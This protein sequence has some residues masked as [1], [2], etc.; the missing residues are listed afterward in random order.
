[1]FNTDDKGIKY[2][3]GIALAL[4][5]VVII[6][7]AMGGQSLFVVGVVIGVAAFLVAWLRVGLVKRYINSHILSPKADKLAIEKTL[8]KELLQHE[9]NKAKEQDLNS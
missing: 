4:V 1:M 5:V 3:V 2:A 7:T 9:I 8:H 6:Y